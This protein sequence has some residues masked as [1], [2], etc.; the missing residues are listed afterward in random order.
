MLDIFFGLL[1]WEIF[2]YYV[3]IVFCYYFFVYWYCVERVLKDIVVLFFLFLD[4]VDGNWEN[5]FGKR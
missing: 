4:E 1:D 5:Y 3:L 2:D